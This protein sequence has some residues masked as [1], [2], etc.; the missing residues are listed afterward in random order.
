M[1]GRIDKRGVA[2]IAVLLMFLLI[3]TGCRAGMNT[4]E[5]TKEDSMPPV[6]APEQ[7]DQ[8]EEDS[9]QAPSI[10]IPGIGED[11]FPRIDGSTAV[12]PLLA[13]LYQGAF[14]ISQEEAE[15]MV[16]VSGGTGAVWRNFIWEGADLLIVYEAP[17]NIKEEFETEGI[18]FEIDPIGRDGLVFLV[19]KNN[20]VDDLSI[21]QLRD[22]F[23]H[24]IPPLQ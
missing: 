20:T 1:I 14:G 4:G 24:G 16:N 19:N 15:V 7:Q 10:T 3:F 2:L 17:E 5:S 21:A 13:A 23:P 12:M 22:I 9:S 8:D 6:S 11:N 18:E